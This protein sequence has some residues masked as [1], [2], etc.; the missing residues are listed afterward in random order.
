MKERISR[1]IKNV[2]KALKEISIIDRNINLERENVLEIIEIVKNYLNDAKYYKENEKLE[3][4]LVSISYC[5]GLLDG[6]RLL[7]AVEF[8]W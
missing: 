8:S 1:Y 7:G 5:E 3:V 4:S 6:L 2:D